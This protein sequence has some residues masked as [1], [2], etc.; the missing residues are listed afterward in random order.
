MLVGITIIFNS[1]II[2]CKLQAG[3]IEDVTK[4][5]LKRDKARTKE[6]ITTDISRLEETLSKKYSDEQEKDIQYYEVNFLKFEEVLFLYENEQA[7]RLGIDWQF[8]NRNIAEVFHASPAEYISET[9]GLILVKKPLII[10]AILED[11]NQLGHEELIEDID[12]GLC[13]LSE[14]D[15]EQFEDIDLKIIKEESIKWHIKPEEHKVLEDILKTWITR[16]NEYLFLDL[17][18]VTLIGNKEEVELLINKGADVNSKD[19]SGGT[20][21]MGAALNGHIEIVKLLIDKNAN[22]NATDNESNT[23]LIYA[24]MNGHKDIVELLLNIGADINLKSKEGATAL[25]YAEKKGFEEI[26]NMLKKAGAKK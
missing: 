3:E 10:K 16:Q 2:V 23:A 4:T 5:L 8:Y 22:L 11:A 12:W 21:L 18:F 15:K 24:T 1:S 13:S 26:V 25:N 14:N 19:I 7:V 20:V 6:A 9:L 17:M